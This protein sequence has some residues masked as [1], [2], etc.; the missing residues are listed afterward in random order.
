MSCLGDEQT[1]KEVPFFGEPCLRQDATF[2][3][4]V[5]GE[6]IEVANAG[7]SR[8]WVEFEFGKWLLPKI[9][10]SLNI[11]DPSIAAMAQESFSTAFAQG[12]HLL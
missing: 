3:H 5:T 8:F 2:R 10:T 9:N 11:L 6:L 4:P 7:C 1:G 12:F